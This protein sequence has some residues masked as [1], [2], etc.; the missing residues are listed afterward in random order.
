M[1]VCV[2]VCVCEGGWVV[3]YV[4]LLVYLRSLLEFS[5]RASFFSGVFFAVVFFVGDACESLAAWYGAPKLAVR[6]LKPS[7]LSSVLVAS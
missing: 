1:C 7:E 2:C 4:D 5:L 6:L 3:C